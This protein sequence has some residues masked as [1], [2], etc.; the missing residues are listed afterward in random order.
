MEGGA[1]T[2]KY[3]AISHNPNYMAWAYFD[4]RILYAADKIYFSDFQLHKQMFEFYKYIVEIVKRHEI[5]VLVVKKLNENGIKK[6]I[7]RDTTTLGVFSS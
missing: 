7:S 6:Y 5:G 2:M 3:L 4:G 1:Q